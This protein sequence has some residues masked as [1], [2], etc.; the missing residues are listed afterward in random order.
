[1]QGDVMN[2][3]KSLKNN[4][5]KFLSFFLKLKNEAI[6]IYAEGKRKAKYKSRQDTM[7][8]EDKKRKYQ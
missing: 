5:D 1:M 6:N 2:T 7:R 4:L 3:S 8:G